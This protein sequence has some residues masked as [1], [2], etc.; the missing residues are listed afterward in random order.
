MTTHDLG[1]VS[2]ELPD[3]WVDEVVFAVHAPLD[4]RGE[5]RPALTIVF[6]R[7]ASELPF[8]ERVDRRLLELGRRAPPLPRVQWFGASERTRIANRPAMR[9]RM[10]LAGDRGP[11]A[12]IAAMLDPQEDPEGGMPVITCSSRADQADALAPTF[13]AM[14]ASLRE[15]QAAPSRARGPAADD[16]NGMPVIPIPGQPAKDA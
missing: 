3:N 8:E 14:L 13:E 12:W 2:L 7:E 10:R 4:R 15:G 1:Y 11:I 9:V 16:V 6:D 5:P